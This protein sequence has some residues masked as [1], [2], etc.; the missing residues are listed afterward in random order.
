MIDAP[1]SSAAMQALMQTAYGKYFGK[2]GNKDYIE[3]NAQQ[4]EYDYNKK[5][6]AFTLDAPVA[7]V[8]YLQLKELEIKNVVS[9]IEGVR[10]GLSPAEISKVIVDT[11]D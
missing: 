5:L 3:G 9:I 8:A 10:Y 7:V 6:L 2:S 1:D 11:G 4:I